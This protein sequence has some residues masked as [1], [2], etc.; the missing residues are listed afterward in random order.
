MNKNEKNE[1]QTI[2][3]IIL[4]TGPVNSGKTSFTFHTGI[5][6]D[7]YDVYNFDV[8]RPL[9]GGKRPQEVFGFYREYLGIMA[10]KKELAM[11]E[12]FLSD[13]EANKKKGTSRV[14]VIDGEEEFRRNFA[15]YTKKHKAELRDY[16]FGRGGIW[17]N[18]EELGFAKKFEATLF[19]SL[20]QTYDIIFIINHLEGVRDESSEKDEKP[21]I[22]GKKKADVREPL[23]QK[24]VA[25]FWLTPTDGHLC[26]SAIVLKNP[27][28]H[29][30]D[31]NGM[32]RTVTLFPPKLSPFALPDWESRQYITLW[33]VIRHYEK[34]PFSAK[35]PKVEPYERLT[36]D[37][38]EMV[39][40]D[41]TE[42]DKRLIEQMALVI[43]KENHERTVTAVTKIIAQT[44][45]APLP[46]V[47]G[48][49]KAELPDI[50]V[51]K[52]SVEAI[53]SE[54]KGE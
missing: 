18:Y 25:R 23:I 11:I 24:S 38:R 45:N 46:F 43:Q 29:E 50:T 53:V 3:G 51:T 34:N 9:F 7:K 49:V 37:E 41:L 5:P 21:L 54:L 32:V 8:K 47:W 19:A 2:R 35:Y 31:E 52:E 1:T 16:W 14:A 6:L 28:F 36:D 22:P 13:V 26:P 39:S 40:E 33:D 42:S 48:R 4:V 30:V 12:A 20:Q 17:Q 27:G 10:E 44:P 15:A